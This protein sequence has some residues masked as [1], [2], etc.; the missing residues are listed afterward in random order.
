MDIAGTSTVELEV[1]D[2]YGKTYVI[3]K[4]FM[5]LIKNGLDATKI[6]GQDESLI[7]PSQARDY[8]SMLDDVAHMHGGNQRIYESNMNIPLKY[9]GKDMFITITKATKE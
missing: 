8:G 9:D 6:Q 5:L 1:C 3:N 4:P 2:A 7:H